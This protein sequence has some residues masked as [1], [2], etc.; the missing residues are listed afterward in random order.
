MRQMTTPAN[1]PSVDDLWAPAPDSFSWDEDPPITITGIVRRQE[2]GQQTDIK[3][4]KPL[5]W[6]DGRPRRKIVVYMSEDDEPIK[7]LHVNI[8]GG[9]FSAIQEAV[10]EADLTTLP[11]GVRLTTTYTEAV[12]TDINGA[13][14]AKGMSKRKLFEA[15]IEDA[16]VGASQTSAEAPF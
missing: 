5:F 4:R 14:L 11:N 12:D 6:E 1:A 9:L 3:T 13:K 16:E 2:V 8:P 10:K 15:L 7:A